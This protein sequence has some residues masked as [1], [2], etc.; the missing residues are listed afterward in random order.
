LL[1]I[2]FD[3]YENQVG[4]GLGSPGNL[5]KNVQ[6]CIYWAGKTLGYQRAVLAQL[7][8]T[9]LKVLIENERIRILNPKLFESLR[10]I[11][12]AK[13]QLDASMVRSNA[14]RFN[15][16]QQLDGNDSISSVFFQQDVD[17]R[18]NFPTDQQFGAFKKQRDIFY[19]I[20]R[21]WEFKHLDPTWSF[22]QDLGGKVKQLLL[23]MEHPINFAH[24]GKLFVAQLIISCH[25]DNSTNE[26]QM[27]LP[28]IDPSKLSKLRQRL[29][30]PSLFSTNYLFPGTQAF[31]KDFILSC[32]QNAMF[33]EQLKVALIGEL[34]EINDSSFESLTVAL[35]GEG[36]K[37]KEVTEFIVSVLEN[38]INS[39]FVKKTLQISIFFEKL[40]KFQFLQKTLRM[41][42]F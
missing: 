31:F 27:A 9:T 18:D 35:A 10:Q 41:S 22:K 30:A 2:E 1:N 28:N 24:L 36:E 13:S 6:N 29:I 39:N 12:Q 14:L 3:P 17:N 11:H 25:F 5:L 21:A 34:M 26:I 19:S 7:D 38:S 42:F 16:Y 15:K 32:E 37:R 33:I 20:F 40:Y 8:S 23:T 4:Q